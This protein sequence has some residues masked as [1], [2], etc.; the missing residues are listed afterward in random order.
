[1]NCGWES[2][3][4]EYLQLHRNNFSGFVSKI[5]RDSLVMDSASIENEY[6]GSV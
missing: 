4:R 6:K 2:T 5:V 3:P 1:M